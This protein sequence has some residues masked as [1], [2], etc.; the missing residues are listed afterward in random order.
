MEEAIVIRLNIGCGPD[1][2]EGWVNIDAAYDKFR[3]DKAM[4]FPDE[5]LSGEYAEDSIDEIYMCDV[6]EHFFRW[7]G[8]KVLKD[9]Y[10]VLKPG[11]IVTI[12]TPD[13]ER[14]IISPT[15]TLQRKTELIRGA[16]GQ[17]GPVAAGKQL[18]DAWQTY[19]KLFSHP[20][21]WTDAELRAVM[22]QIGFENCKTTW[23]C[24]WEMVITGRV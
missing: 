7:D 17:P 12:V 20:Y 1:Y 5:K 2:R 10:K 9:F 19:P 14:L 16:Q 23:K 24:D 21:T 3:V 22:G 11:G 4:V 18:A 15:L 6:M 13:L 8:I